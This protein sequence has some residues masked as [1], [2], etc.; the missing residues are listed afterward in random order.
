MHTQSLICH[1]SSDRGILRERAYCI[2]REDLLW[3]LERV[4]PKEDDRTHCLMREIDRELPMVRICESMNH[5]EDM[6]DII[7]A[8]EAV[9]NCDFELEIEPLQQNESKDAKDVSA[10]GTKGYYMIINE[11]IANDETYVGEVFG[12]FNPESHIFH[13]MFPKAVQYAISSIKLGF[14]KGLNYSGFVGMRIYL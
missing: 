5:D 8:C 6:E 1:W 11:E 7:A 12:R 10:L 2:N 9:I 4:H 3:E 13:A 14:K